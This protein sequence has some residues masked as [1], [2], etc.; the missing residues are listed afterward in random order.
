VDDLG[1]RLEAVYRACNQRRFVHPDPLE[2]LYGYASPADQE[3]AGLIAACLA[4]G[5]VA[6]ILTSV[7]R[8]LDPMGSPRAFLRAASPSDLRSLARGFAHRFTT[9]AEIAALLAAIR[10]CLLDHGSLEALFQEGRAEGQPTVLPALTRFVEELRGRAGGAA[11]CASLLSSPEDGSACKR[12]NLYL[13]WMVRK[14]AVDPGCWTGIPPALLVVPLDTHLFRI[15]RSLGLTERRQPNL[16]TAIEVTGGFA[17][18]RPDDPVRYDFCLT[19]LGI[20]P[21]VRRSSWTALVK[22]IA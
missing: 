17:R 21:E 18:I 4:Y 15:A 7:R 11:R 10:S 5:R 3:V 2:L 20:H 1:R 19:R 9:S 8:L 14:D 22:G 12:L 6:Q 16:R 13:R